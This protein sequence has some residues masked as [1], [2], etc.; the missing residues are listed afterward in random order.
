MVDLLEVGA[1]PQPRHRRL[2]VLQALLHLNTF[3]CFDGLTKHS[4]IP[5]GRE[6]SLVTAAILVVNVLADYLPV[7]DL[8]GL[9]SENFVC[10]DQAVENEAVGYY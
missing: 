3:V 4:D 8:E 1:V 7:F 6:E 10:I 2:R 9:F 5:Q